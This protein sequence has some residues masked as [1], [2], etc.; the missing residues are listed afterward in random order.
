MAVTSFAEDW[1]VLTETPPTEQWKHSPDGS[2][3][4][5]AP[6]Q[7]QGK[8]TSAHR[9]TTMEPLHWKRIMA[10]IFLPEKRILPAHLIISTVAGMLSCYALMLRVTSYGKRLSVEVSVMNL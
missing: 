6:E 7:L 8:C 1:P 4:L 9:D 5:T 2:L 3:N 10:I